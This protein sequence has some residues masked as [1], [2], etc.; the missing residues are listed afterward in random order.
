MRRPKGELRLVAGSVL[1]SREA[2]AQ[3]ALLCGTFSSDPIATM[4]PFPSGEVSGG[5]EL[6]PL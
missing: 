3:T 6:P 4:R 1:L 2:V 5:L